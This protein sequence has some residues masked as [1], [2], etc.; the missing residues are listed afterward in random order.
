MP[1][2]LDGVSLIVF[3]PMTHAAHILSV[4][5]EA[6]TEPQILSVVLSGRPG[7]VGRTTCRP[8]PATLTIENRADRRA[9]PGIILAGPGLSALLTDRRRFLTAKRLLSNQT[10]RDLHGADTLDMDQQFKLTSL[11]FLF[12]DLHGS[13]ELY[14]QVGDLAA[15][16]L[17]RA[18]FRALTDLVAEAEG[19]V[20]KTI[21]DAVMVT[22]PEPEQALA[23]ALRMKAAMRRLNDE[24]GVE[25]LALKVGIH[26]GPCLAVSLNDRQDYFGQ[27]VNIAARVQGLATAGTILVTDA[28]AADPSCAA[29]IASRNAGAEARE[30][31]LRGVGASMGVHRLS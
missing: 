28:V 24:R 14:E 7:E 8:G 29:L 15:Y 23:A 9:L 20:V 10:F 2:N 11:T 4:E 27:T 22:F 13:T 12:T 30:V 5:G 31:I 19:A 18:H 3:D 16:D 26:A 21:G 1:L 25:R 17:V 6:G